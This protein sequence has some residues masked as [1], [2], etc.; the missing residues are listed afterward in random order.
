MS[1]VLPPMSPNPAVPDGTPARIPSSVSR[2]S[3]R[4][5]QVLDAQVILLLHSPSSQFEL[6]SNLCALRR[7]DY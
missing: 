7:P 3:A 2:A 4:L 6:H 5:R 1:A